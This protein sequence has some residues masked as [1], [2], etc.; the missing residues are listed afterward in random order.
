MRGY[1]WTDIPVY[2]QDIDGEQHYGSSCGLLRRSVVG[3][4]YDNTIYAGSRFIGCNYNPTF[5]TGWTSTRGCSFNII[6][7]RL[8]RKS[9]TI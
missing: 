8:K 7:G 6:L 5:T 3:C 9:F 4:G 2:N 1:G